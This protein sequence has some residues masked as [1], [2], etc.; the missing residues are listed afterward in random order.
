MNKNKLII[1]LVFVIILLVVIFNY[2]PK[3]SNEPYKK[4][5]KQYD[6]DKTWKWNSENLFNF[7]S[8]VCDK[9]EVYGYN[10]LVTLTIECQCLI[11]Y[12]PASPEDVELIY[13]N[14]SG[15]RLSEEEVTNLFH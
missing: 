7:C 15:S 2:Y 3:N 9:R 14:I 10:G 5:I 4:Y 6:L 11:N 1:V 13:V 8:K 12:P